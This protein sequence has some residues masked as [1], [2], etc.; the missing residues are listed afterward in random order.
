MP[1]GLFGDYSIFGYSLNPTVMN[2]YLLIYCGMHFG[3]LV[4]LFF[5]LIFQYG[6]M[7]SIK[8]QL[9]KNM[10][11]VF[12]SDRNFERARKFLIRSSVGFTASLFF[13]FLAFW[14]LWMAGTFDKW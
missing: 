9:G 3:I 12:E 8:I 11:D 2:I 1:S 10:K 14:L 6:R 4:L 5:N 7:K 13:Q